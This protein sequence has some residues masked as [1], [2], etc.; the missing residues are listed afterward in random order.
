MVN[1]KN[2]EEKVKEALLKR[3]M[4][5]EYEEKEIIADKTG[6]P[7]KIKVI[8]K[9]MPPDIEAIKLVSIRIKQGNW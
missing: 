3:A 9:H 1:K 7:G 2:D 8:K 6:K 5:Y 4:G